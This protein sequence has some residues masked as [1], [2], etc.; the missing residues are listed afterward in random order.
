MAFYFL[1]HTQDMWVGFNMHVDYADDGTLLFVLPI[2]DQKPLVFESLNTYL[3]KV[4]S[5]NVYMEEEGNED[6]CW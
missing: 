1:L 3:A 5:W 4:G 6:E 2:S